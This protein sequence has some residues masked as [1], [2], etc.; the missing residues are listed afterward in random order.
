MNWGAFI[1]AIILTMIVLGLSKL[2]KTDPATSLVVLIL[3]NYYYD[4]FD[5]KED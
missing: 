4:K 1:Y 5:N 3:F 2:L